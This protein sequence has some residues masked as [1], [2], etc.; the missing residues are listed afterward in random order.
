[1]NF[2][3]IKILATN[4]KAQFEYFL[5]ARYEAGIVLLGSEIKS[6]RAGQISIMESYI[7][8]DK[9]QVWLMEAHIAPY[10]SANRNNHD[11]KRAKK[12]LLHQKEIRELSNSIQ[13]KGMTIVPLK[14]YLKE[15]KAKLE[16]AIAKG[17]KLYD[18]RQ[19]IAKRDAEREALRQR[20]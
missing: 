2:M 6:I 19:A 20:S 17:K 1:M 13:Q 16:F 11:P 4:R 8:I 15:G 3:G 9:G 14:I 12:L 10:E 18:K 7:Q 5:F